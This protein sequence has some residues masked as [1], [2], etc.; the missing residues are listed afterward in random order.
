MSEPHHEAPGHGEHHAPPKGKKGDK[1][2]GGISQKVLVVAAVLTVL[3]TYLLYRRSKASAAS[4]TTDSTTA[5]GLGGQPAD[6]GGG[7]GGSSS[8]DTSSTTSSTSSS[9]G[10]TSPIAVVSDKADELIAEANGFL[11]S[12]IRYAGSDPNAGNVNAAAL[13]YDAP[14]DLAT[15]N[16]GTDTGAFNLGLSGT[17]GNGLQSIT[18]ADRTQTAEELQVALGLPVTHSQ[19]AASGTTGVSAP[20]P[21]V[22]GKTVTAAIKQA[23]PAAAPA[24][25]ASKPA[26]IAA[27]PATVSHAAKS[28]VTTPS[29]AVQRSAQ[30]QL[31]NLPG[32]HKGE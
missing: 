12:Q 18:G 14:T 11:P 24:P 21:P 13:G 28:H 9:G 10:S 6:Y 20:A 30:S 19:A 26:T 22:A 32:G 27:H 17:L 3:L 7:G 5:N 1:K 15:Y 25:V 23:A 16:P 4:S 29:P 2:I 31:V 8:G